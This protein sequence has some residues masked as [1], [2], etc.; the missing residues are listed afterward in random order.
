M[1]FLIITGM[2]GAGKS[3]TMKILEDMGY[4]CM[5]NL[6]PNLLPQIAELFKESKRGMKKIAVVIDTRG[7]EFFHGLFKSLDELN[8]M[9]IGYKILF[10]D[11]SDNVIIKRYK[12]LRRVHPLK[13]EGRI[14][15]GIDEERELL[16]ELKEKAYFIIDTSNLNL[17]MLKE[18]IYRLFSEG[19]EKRKLTISLISFGFKNGVL[20]DADLLFD[21][22]FLPNPFYIPEL[23]EHSGREQEVK[24]YVFK[25]PQTNI[26][27]SKLIDML[28]FL[29]PY[30]V[31]EGKTQ[32][33][34]GIGCTGGFHRSVAIT[35][36]VSEILKDN[37]HRAISNHR[38]LKR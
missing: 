19:G 10:I 28:E 34:V 13:P 26:F 4:Y 21:V 27:I 20:S 33:V 9:G 17:G 29:I 31:K 23:K 24:D 6:P 12:E 38:D 5:D 22:R 30:Y 1:D 11:A 37:G 36:K 32:L 2:S 18:E 3:Q 7:G 16:Q 35:N 15:E 14:I 25:W 8:N